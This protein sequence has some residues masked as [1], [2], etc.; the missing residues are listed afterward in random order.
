[1]TADEAIELVRA[2]GFLAQRREYFGDNAIYVAHQSEVGS[3]KVLDPALVISLR[4]G[5]WVVP[6]IVTHGNPVPKEDMG[7][8]NLESAV[9]FAL[10]VLRDGWPVG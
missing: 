2:A 4:E 6:S 9:E 3:I 8:E 1:M 7:F 5:R 10:R